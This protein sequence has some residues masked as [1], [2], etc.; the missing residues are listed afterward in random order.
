MATEICDA[1]HDNVATR[2]DID[3]L[4]NELAIAV[5]GLKIWAG[6][7]CG[8]RA[9]TR[10]AASMAAATIATELVDMSKNAVS[11]RVPSMS[12]FAQSA[13]PRRRPEPAAR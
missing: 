11:G 5:R 1:I 13:S 4:R 2:A 10:R 6:P 8:R 7:I 9:P 12:L 3:N